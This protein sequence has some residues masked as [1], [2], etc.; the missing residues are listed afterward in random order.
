MGAI[1]PAPQQGRVIKIALRT[2]VAAT[3][4]D[5]L[6]ASPASRNAFMAG[7]RCGKTFCSGLAS[8]CARPTLRFKYRPPPNPPKT[9]I[10]NPAAA[11]LSRL[12]DSRRSV[13]DFLP[14]PI[15]PE[16]LNAVL[17][18]ANHAPSW[19]NTQPY[20]IAVASGTVRDTLA[21]QLTRQFDK[22]MAA[23]GGG[24]FGKLKIF[25]TR[26]G[27]PDGDF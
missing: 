13:R 18:D 3:A 12:V 7:Y 8:T 9:M 22:G 25:A 23:Q 4:L 17:S 15:A 24:W 6:W 1:Q 14:Q 16:L 26:D 11:T 20:R 27:L 21:A 19:S 5:D 2:V 10:T